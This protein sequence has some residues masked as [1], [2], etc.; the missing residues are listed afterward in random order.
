[1]TG[2]T[3]SEIEA[4][5]QALKAEFRGLYGDVEAI[6]FR[7]DPI[8]INFE[9]NTDEYSPEV[10]T[11]LPRLKGCGSASAV[12]DVV[13]EEF[14]RWFSDVGVGAKDDYRAIANEIWHAWVRFKKKGVGGEK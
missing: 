12:L 13:Y 11:I 10:S 1:M 8:G 4:E 6:L 14:E 5:K 9:D 3:A 2:R 7:H